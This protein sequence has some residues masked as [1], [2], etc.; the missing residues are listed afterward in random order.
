MVAGFP[1]AV[2][3]GLYLPDALMELGPAHDAKVLAQQGAALVFAVASVAVTGPAE[4]AGRFDVYVNHFAPCLTFI[5]APRL[6]WFHFSQS[7]DTEAFE[8]G[9]D[10]GWRNFDI[11]GDALAC[12]TQ[13]AHR[14]DGCDDN[15]LSWVIQSVRPR[16]TVVEARSAGG[17][18]LIN[19]NIIEVSGTGEVCPVG[20]KQALIATKPLSAPV[21]NT[22]GAS[23]RGPSTWKLQL[24]DRMT[25]M[26]AGNN[27]RLGNVSA[28]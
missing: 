22:G 25:T 21:R 12:P 23:F 8:D 10:S 28:T 24:R 18:D 2:E 20:K 14:F 27:V 3:V 1:V 17:A 9:A 26:M 11:G 4:L 7:V 5:M 16:G 13:L 15:C 6:S 19:T